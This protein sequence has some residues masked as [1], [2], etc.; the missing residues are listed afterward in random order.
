MGKKNL[1]LLGALL[2]VVAAFNACSSKPDKA[3]IDR[4]F[5]AIQLNDVTTM[6]TIAV[7]P[8]DIDFKSFEIVRLGEAKVEPAALPE[9]TKKEAELKKKLED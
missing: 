7:S 1:C 8:M 2:L 3:V 5:H 6:S 9:M 4:Y